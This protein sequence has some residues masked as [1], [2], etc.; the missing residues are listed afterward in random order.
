MLS[1]PFI[2]LWPTYNEVTSLLCSH[3]QSTNYALFVIQAF[4]DGQDCS[5]A[6]IFTD[7]LDCAKY[8]GLVEFYYVSR[9]FNKIA[10]DNARKSYDLMFGEAR[11]DAF[12]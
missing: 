1:G 11:F 4:K 5:I 6:L 2:T 12:P 7:I 10:H 9:T 8:F 3:H